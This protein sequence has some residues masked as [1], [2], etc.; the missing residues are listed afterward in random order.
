[1]VRKEEKK[2]LAESQY[3]RPPIVAVMGHV[4]HG[5][6][7]LLD[8]IRSSQV[9]T[10]EAGGIT[11]KIGAYQVDLKGQKITFIDTP[12]HQ[13]FSAMR[14][15]GA[16]VADLVVL[17]VAADDGVMPQTLES[18][19][20]IKEAGVPFLVALNKID[21]PNADPDR[22]KKQLSANDIKVEGYGGDIV[23]VPVSAKTGQ[24]IDELLEMILLMAEMAQIKS[25]PKNPFLAVVIESKTSAGG[26][27][28]T[29][30]IQDG[31]LKV[32]DQIVVNVVISKVRGMMNDLGKN[33]A[34]AGPST[35]VELIGFVNLPPVGAIVTKNDGSQP[36]DK[37]ILQ[38]SKIEIPALASD[39]FKIILRA[40]SL[41][42]LEAILASLPSNVF[43]IMSGVGDINE[44]DILALKNME[45]EIYGF[46]IK[47]PGQVQKLAESEKVK[48]KTF[49][50]IYELLENLEK[51]GIDQDA[52]ILKKEVL[53]RA[54]ILQVFKMGG[55]VIAG[56]RVLQGRINISDNFVLKRGERELG[57]FKMTSMK[58]LKSDIRESLEGEDFGATFATKLDFKVGD[59][60]L[61][62]R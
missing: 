23:C 11:Q 1:M 42:S 25:D 6:T 45:A 27:V 37:A 51:A 18:V 41:G 19:R 5:K 34:E 60:L 21:L 3:I 46:N 26:P 38:N 53:G 28:G 61:S 40:D 4:D 47:I 8:K 12:G 29:L 13:T 7:S 2:S 49:K 33:V 56:C 31:T 54:E 16:N 24:G 22:V 20:F 10:R 30:I 44:S 14:S 15:R 62:G 48:I 55:D 9:A 59:V 36:F 39:K 32:G 57:S 17:V 50:I 43:V 52:S 35:P 58:H